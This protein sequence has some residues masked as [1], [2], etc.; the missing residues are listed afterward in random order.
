MDQIVGRRA[1][2][3]A[4]WGELGGRM[5]VPA[6]IG[7]GLQS[8]RPRPSDVVI[9]PYAKCG[10]TW[11]QQIFHTLR[12]RGDFDFD[13]ISRVVPWLEMAVIAG[14][15]LDAPQRAEPRGFKS[16]LSYAMVPKGARY[17]VA[18]RD[19]K[20][21][22]VSMFRFMEGW[23]IEPGTVLIDDF[24]KAWIS[25]SEDGRDYWSHL[26]SWWAERDNPDVLILSY[27]GMNAAPEATI[28]QVAAFAGIPLDDELLA[29]TL[30]RS[31]FPFM[32]KHKD[33]F[34]DLLMR[35]ASEARCNLPPGSDSAKVRKGGSGGYRQELSPEISAAL[36]AKWAE[37]VTPVT[38]FADYAALE[39]EIRRRSVG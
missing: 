33:R 1:R 25:R 12:T 29:L 2:S 31:S 5:F 26:L 4:E 17:V 18:F 7:A 28:R 27:E 19:P 37:L 16:H 32:L 11:L 24:A 38:G 36:D 6:D 15:D 35:T 22:V 21:A 8:Y 3:L 9:T 20:D 30:E 10:T 13:D 34:D 23:F 14:V 39:A